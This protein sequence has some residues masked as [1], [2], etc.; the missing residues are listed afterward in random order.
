[1][2]ERNCSEVI[3]HGKRER[4]MADQEQLDILKQ[5]GP[6]WNQWRDK[7]LDI[8]PNLSGAHLGGAH[9]T[10]VDFSRASLS[11]A[12][13]SGAILRDTDFSRANLKDADLSGSD[14]RDADLSY[15]DLGRS[16]FNKA[17]LSGADLIRADFSGANLTNAN[18]TNANLSRADVSTTVALCRRDTSLKPVWEQNWLEGSAR[19]RVG[20]KSGSHLFQT[21]N[22]QMHGLSQPIGVVL[23]IDASIGHP[24]GAAF[25]A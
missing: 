18:L 19:R 11:G 13:L 5:G 2:S 3:D 9:L 21:S 20:L 10:A 24:T 6:A 14:L 1:M 4:A 15:A 23:R 16:T 25:G 8:R 12:D 22:R 7:Y 17:D